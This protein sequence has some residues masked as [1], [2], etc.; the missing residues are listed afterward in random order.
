MHGN[1]GLGT[2]GGQ[3]KRSRS[4]KKNSK[5]RPNKDPNGIFLYHHHMEYLSFNSL[6][7]TVITT[8][9]E[10]ESE[11]EN[12]IKRKEIFFGKYAKNINLNFIEIKD[13]EWHEFNNID[14]LNSSKN[15][16]LFSA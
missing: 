3:N 13:T 14:D 15:K 9:R 5:H 1:N 2:G 11:C 8:S 7:N 10:R 4:R 16:N 6:K 12:W